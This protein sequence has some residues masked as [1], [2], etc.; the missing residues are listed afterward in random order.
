MLFC[1]SK[2][3]LTT[4]LPMATVL[5]PGHAVGL[6]VVPMLFHR[7]QLIVCAALAAALARAAP[8]DAGAP[9]DP[10]VA[11]TVELVAPPAAAPRHA[12]TAPLSLSA[13][14]PRPPLVMLTVTAG[15]DRPTAPR[16]TRG[17]RPPPAGELNDRH[18]AEPSTG[19]GR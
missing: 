12:A 10:A 16:T 1:G 11:D 6:L 5:F 15:P 9:D 8:T 2:K 14:T 17:H 7:L 3:S 13:P 18:T 4:G 19:P